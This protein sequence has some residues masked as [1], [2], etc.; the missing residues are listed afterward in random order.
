MDQTS[1]KRPISPSEDEKR[2]RIKILSEI[3]SKVGMEVPDAPEMSHGDLQKAITKRSSCFIV[4]ASC[5]LTYFPV[6]PNRLQRAVPGRPCRDPAIFTA[7]FAN[8]LKKAER[9]RGILEA[10]LF[11]PLDILYDVRH[12]IF[13]Y[14]R[15][16]TLHIRFLCI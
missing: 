5:K 2:K 15:S 7:A 10:L 4:S 16:H 3:I 1:L 12:R 8:K 6:E 14:I 13:V 11:A 9:S